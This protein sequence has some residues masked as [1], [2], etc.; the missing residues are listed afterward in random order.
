M[1][2]SSVTAP[3]VYRLRAGVA[4]DS[5]GDPVESW[6]APER[7]RLK[8]ASVQNVSVIEEE[9]TAR[10]IIRGRKTLYAP[11]RVDLTAHDRIEA[12]GEVWKVAGDPVVRAGLAS[13]VYTTAELERV[14]IG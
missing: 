13:C 12:G 1:L 9:G 2:L 11:G 14:T 6:D 5:Y 10:H 3:P 7:V 8:G 4:V